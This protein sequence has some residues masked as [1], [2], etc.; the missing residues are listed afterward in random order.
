M[1]H[2]DTTAAPTAKSRSK[3]LLIGF[4]AVILLLGG[5]G[6]GWWYVKAKAA[7]P[8]TEK[9][10][11]ETEASGLVNFAPFT[12]NLADPGGRRYLRVALQLVVPDENIAKKATEDELVKSRV[13]SEL[14]ETLAQS[15]S[16]ELNTTAGRTEL[17]K[18]IAE[19]ASHVG[20]MDV[21]DV[22]FEDFVVQ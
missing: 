17:K 9:V 15:T 12:V 20:H 21:R 13:R 16:T 10:V 3:L 14:I 8:G 22:L 5:A 6:A 4:P 2:T 7:T 19:V 18:K 11:A 1:S